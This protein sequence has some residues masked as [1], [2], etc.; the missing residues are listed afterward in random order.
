MDIANVWK[1][2]EKMGYTNCGNSGQKKNN[3]LLRRQFLFP[4]EIN[5]M[6]KIFEPNKNAEYGSILTR[7]SVLCS[8][9]A[10]NLFQCC[11]LYDILFFIKYRAS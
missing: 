2:D 8:F 4:F 10:V 3:N 5:F 1:L 11:R 7:Q 9:V 6:G